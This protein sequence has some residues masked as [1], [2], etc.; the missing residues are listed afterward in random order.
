MEIQIDVAN[1]RAAVVG[2]PTIVC[3]NSGYS[4]KFNFDDEWAAEN[5]KTARFVFTK[6]SEVKY[7]D[8]DFDGSV[9][10]VPTLSGINEVFV[11]VYVGDRLTTTSASIPCVRSIRCHVPEGI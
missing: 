7:I 4:V 5:I 2:S 11:G 1:K 10:P 3:G 9:A 6:G 8:V